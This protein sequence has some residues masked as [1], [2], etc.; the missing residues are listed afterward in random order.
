MGKYIHK[1]DSV[2]D[3][4]NQYNSDSKIIRITTQDHGAYRYNGITNDGY[5]QWISE[6][7][8]ESLYSEYIN[9]DVGSDVCSLD[10]YV[11]DKVT[12]VSQIDNQTPYLEPWVS[13]TSNRGIDY[14]KDDPRLYKGGSIL[15]LTG[16]KDN[17]NISV[18]N[19]SSANNKYTKPPHAY[20][21]YYLKQ[22]VQNVFANCN[23]NPVITTL[24]VDDDETGTNTATLDLNASS[25]DSFAYYTN[26]T[27]WVIY[28]GPHYEIGTNYTGD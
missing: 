15:D 6:T 26:G 22:F 7:D 4:N 20:C 19:Y 25:G 8:Q 1:F 13:Y 27:P 18:D 9:V 16:I 23:G 17:P 21:Y 10:G 14:N 24:L 5:H 3:F 12:S 2:S 28:L 11:N